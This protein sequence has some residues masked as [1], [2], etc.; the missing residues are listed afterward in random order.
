MPFVDVI[1]LF[2][3]P[4]EATATNI[5]SS[6]LQH[7]LFQILS[8]AAALLVQFIPSGL[9]ITLLVPEEATAINKFNS[10]LQHTEVQ[11]LALADVL[12]VQFI[13]SGDVIVLDDAPDDETATNRPI[14]YAQQTEVHV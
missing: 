8:T 1:T 10:G 7:T 2:P 9:L 3:V 12:K 13:P 4:E 11:G 6:G 14:E 5:K